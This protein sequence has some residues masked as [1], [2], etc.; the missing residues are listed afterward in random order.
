MNIG[1]A[2]TL[3]AAL[4]LFAAQALR[5]LWFHYHPRALVR[6]DKAVQET[7]NVICVAVGFV[8]ALIWIWSSVS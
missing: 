3:S 5:A 7:I 1:L 2:I 4:V 8:G 6:T